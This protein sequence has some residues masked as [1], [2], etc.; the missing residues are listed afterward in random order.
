MDKLLKYLLYFSLTSLVIGPLGV[1][2]LNITG[3]NLYLT[4]IFVALTCLVLL[5]K[6]P[7]II[8]IIKTDKISIY[9]LIFA[10]VGLFSLLVSPVSLTLIEK[11][12]SGLYLIRLIAYFGV[13]LALR[14]LLTIKILSAKSIMKWLS[15]SG[16]ALV[17]LGWLQYLLYPDLRNL[18]YLGWDPHLKRIF[19][20]YLDPNYFGLMMVLTLIL[21]FES[22]REIFIR[23]TSRKITALLSAVFLTLMFTYSRSSYLAL[24]AAAFSYAVLK[25]KYVIFGTAL[26]LVFIIAALLPRPEGIGVRL[27]RVFSAV[28]RAE[29]WREGVKLFTKHPVLGVGFN[30]VRYA[31][32]QYGLNDAFLMV[33]HAGAGYDN[34]FIFIAVTSGM[35]GLAAYL[36]FLRQAYFSGNLL[37][38]LSL[39]AI[40]IHSFF[41]NSLFFPWIML[42]MW[43]VIA[44]G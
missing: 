5:L 8:K 23:K 24:L 31:K 25:K 28:E 20:T 30:T 9:F 6:A 37:V 21:L 34:S 44:A 18:Y 40:V 13:Y 29:N 19:A 10:I 3:V 43:V 27:E 17:S 2:P 35:I 42:W 22:S 12:I 38:K 16:L 36:L 11:L 1:I 32:R 33:S 4:D 39:V 26:I 41:L 14:Y 15:M 7:A